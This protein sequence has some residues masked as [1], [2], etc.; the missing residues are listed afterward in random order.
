M[1]IQNL[2]LKNKRIMTALGEVQFNENGKAEV[3][4]EQ[5]RRLSSLKGFVVVEEKQE[6]DNKQPE[7]DKVV[8]QNEEKDDVIDK[9]NESFTGTITL[10]EIKAA[11]NVPILKKIAKD[12]NIDVEGLAKKDEIANAIIEGLGL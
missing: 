9:D 8:S 1:I 12:N 5:G 4:D 3:Q 6:T 11:K 2:G 7:Q 10:E